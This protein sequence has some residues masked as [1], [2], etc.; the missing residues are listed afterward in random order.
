MKSEMI[1]G[2][3]TPNVV[4]FNA[5]HSINEGELRRYVNWLIEKGVT[6]LYSMKQTNKLRDW[7]RAWTR[8]SPGA[9]D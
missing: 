9:S 8:P 6:G 1:Q 7:Q 3:Y 2:I 5:D 4:P